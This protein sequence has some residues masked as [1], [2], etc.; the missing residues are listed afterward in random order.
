MTTLPSSATIGAACGAALTPT[1]RADHLDGQLALHRLGEVVFDDLVGAGC[2]SQDRTASS[3]RSPHRVAFRVVRRFCVGPGRRV[4]AP[5]ARE[6]DAPAVLSGRPEDSGWSAAR[7]GRGEHGGPPRLQSDLGR[8]PERCGP[9]SGVLKTRRVAGSTS[10]SG[11]GSGRAGE[12]SPGP[13]RRSRHS[14]R[15]APGVKAWPEP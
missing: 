1:A 12:R 10:S 6:G 8:V 3:Q 14:I 2:L 15:C 5:T 11:C 4:V 9:G 7:R 13:E